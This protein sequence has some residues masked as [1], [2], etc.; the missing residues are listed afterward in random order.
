LANHGLVSDSVPSPHNPTVMLHGESLKLVFQVKE[1]DRILERHKSKIFTAYSKISNAS[2]DFS[3]FRKYEFRPSRGMST[4]MFVRNSL[5]NGIA[6]WKY[7]IERLL[8]R[9]LRVVNEKKEVIT[10]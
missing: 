2:L 1:N 4:S 9:L 6:F 3:W 7:R 5:D 10:E 8:Y